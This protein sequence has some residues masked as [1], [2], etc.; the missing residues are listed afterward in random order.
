MNKKRISVAVIITLGLIYFAVT[1]IV[2]VQIEKGKNKIIEK[3]PYQVSPQAQT[4]YNSLDFIADLHSDA[5]LWGRDLTKKTEL[6]HVDF[7]RMQEAKIGMQTFTIVTKAPADQSF[8]NTKGDGFD[9]LTMLNIVQGKPLSNWFSLF[10]RAIKQVNELHEYRDKYNNQFEII[11]TRNDF[12]S[13]LE[14]RSQNKK[15]TSGFLGIEGAHCLEGDLSN[16]DKLFEAGVRMVGPTHFFDNELGGSA[17]GIS[18]EGLTAFGEQV[19]DRM[20]E[21]GI[22][23]DLSHTSSKMIDDILERTTTPII[24]SHTGVNGTYESP[25][26][27]TDEQLQAIAKNGGLVGIAFFKGALPKVGVKEIVDAMKYVKDFIGIKHVALGSDFDGVI[28]A[29]FDI[30]GF[31]LIVEEMLRQDFTE[32][33]IRAIMGDNIKQF[34]LDNL[35]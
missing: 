27:L 16:L 30:T 5:L 1:K 13:F 32:E 15:L 2:P 17:H 25:R 11:K 22:I 35:K 8:Q 21:L 28:K 23:I 24:V 33:E 26:N 19:I 7:P 9:N 34:L 18:H 29:P 12:T 6:G 10:N 20:N 14:R 3:P 31:P 4:L